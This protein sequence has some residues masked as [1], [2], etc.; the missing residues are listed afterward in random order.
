MFYHK[1]QRPLTGMD[2]SKSSVKI[3]QILRGK[4]GWR[5]LRA[6]T[7][8]FPED[9]LR[10]SLKTKNINDPQ[11]FLETV[12]ETLSLFGKGIHRVGLSIP[13]ESVKVMIQGYTG[14]PNSGEQAEKMIAWLAKK[15]LPFP[16]DRTKISHYTLTGKGSDKRTLLLALAFDDVIKE[17]ELNLRELKLEPEM[18]R[19]AGI[20][21]LNF[22]S[23]R[24]PRSGTV[25]FMG[26]FEDFF[27]LFV[28][29][30]GNFL[31]YHGVKRGFSNIHF[32]Q[33]V[34]MTLHLFKNEKVGR[35]IEKLYFGSQVGFDEPLEEGLR[36]LGEMAIVRMHEDELISMNGNSIGL[37]EGEIRS[38]ASAIGAAQSLTQ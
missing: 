1:F 14:L 2:I 22:Y 4:K 7:L 27:T 36:T 10:L 21:Q 16:A 38:Y 31:F 28:C 29:V 9:T 5:L 15:S 23:D 30:H 35:K 32:F 13:N 8:A 6:E 19:P 37:M 34:D 24:I 33:D 11:A 18:I 26:L 12:R 17:Y 25:G 3:V 20:N